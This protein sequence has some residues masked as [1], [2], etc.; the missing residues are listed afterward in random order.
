[1]NAIKTLFKLTVGAAAVF[2]LFAV[3][4]FFYVEQKNDMA[5]NI[6]ICVAV[7]IIPL[8]LMRGLIFWFIKGTFIV[9]LI[10]G[11]FA[12]LIAGVAK[13]FPNVLDSASED[14]V[15]ILLG[16]AV[17]I[18]ALIV[19]AKVLNGVGG[20][21]SKVNIKVSAPRSAPSRS[22]ARTPSAPKAAPAPQ[23]A[24]A[25]RVAPAPQV[26]PQRLE[27][28]VA[29]KRQHGYKLTYQNITA[30]KGNTNTVR[31]LFSGGPTECAMALESGELSGQGFVP[32]CCQIV[33]LEMTH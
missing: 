10:F 12:A 16:G 31:F 5:G 8:W 33:K 19:V 6:T 28:V 22:I 27:S 17:V 23:V 1:M 3:A 30:S 11:G 4:G 26:A 25:P 13:F 18:V 24:P 32:S 7:G 15:A 21:L 29:P 14:N 9:T 20:A 2:L